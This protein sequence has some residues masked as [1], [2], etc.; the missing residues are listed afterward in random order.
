L[1]LTPLAPY[2]GFVA[3]PP[4]FYLVVAAM[5]LVYLFAAEAAKDFFYRYLA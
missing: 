5:V 4:L 2:L 1:P 3:P